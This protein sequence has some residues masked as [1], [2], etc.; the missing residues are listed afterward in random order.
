MIASAG[1]FPQSSR[2]IAV[3]LGFLRL[4]CCK[5]GCCCSIKDFKKVSVASQDVL[6]A[7]RIITDKDELFTENFQV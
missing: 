7:D 2:R 5:M 6:D 3:K 4:A 1:R